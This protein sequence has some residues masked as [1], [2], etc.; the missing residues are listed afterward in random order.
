MKIIGLIGG[1]SWHS[2]IDYYRIINEQVNNLHG[3]NTSAKIFLYSVDYG[4]IVSLTQKDDWH[5]IEL[6][7]CEAAQMLEDAGAACI[8][9]CANTMHTIADK[10]QLAIQIPLLHI[11]DVVIKAIEVKKI[12]TVLLL[13]TK[14]T[15]QGSFYSE[16]LVKNGVRLF[17]PDSDEIEQINNSI[18]NELGK[19]LLLPATKDMY[20]EIINKY[21]AL[22]AEGVILGC[23]EIPLLIQQAD[24]SVPV[25]NTTLLHASA[26]VT[27][28]IE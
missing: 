27:F 11:V 3:G 24:C 18:Y 23:T 4:E 12:K 26:A 22:G 21:I 10:I 9:L 13:G 6:I 28:A 8:L 19:G 7:I 17:I 16:R 14:Y 2:T 25:L 15:M 1:T 5:G 20:L